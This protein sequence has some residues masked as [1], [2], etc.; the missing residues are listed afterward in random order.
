MI[1]INLEAS[2]L[3]LAGKLKGLFDLEFNDS[4]HKSN[5]NV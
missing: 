4:Q 3:A 2:L 5:N 1:G